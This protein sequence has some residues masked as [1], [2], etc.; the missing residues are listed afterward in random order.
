V[1]TKG[2]LRSQ[3]NSIPQLTAVAKPVA[4]YILD[5]PSTRLEHLNKGDTLIVQDPVEALG[6]MRVVRGEIAVTLEPGS[7]RIISRDIQSRHEHETQSNS[8]K[9]ITNQLKVGRSPE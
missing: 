2:A 8:I 1:P 4:E 5:H 3:L 6:F 7:V 9:F